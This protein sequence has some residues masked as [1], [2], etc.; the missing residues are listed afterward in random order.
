[1]GENCE[2]ICPPQTSGNACEKKHSSVLPAYP[3]EACGG[4]IHK[5]GTYKSAKDKDIQLCTWWIQSPKCQ[6]AVVTITEFYLQCSAEKFCIRSA[7]IYETDEKYKCGRQIKPGSKFI[8][9][10]DLVVDFQ[11]SFKPKDRKG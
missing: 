11:S 6:I 3:L 4:H 1:L 9:K 5:P 7:S 2:C 8:G 10:A